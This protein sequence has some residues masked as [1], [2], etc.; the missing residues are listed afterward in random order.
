MAADD[1]EPPHPPAAASSHVIEAAISLFLPRL[2]FDVD[3][4]RRLDK[5]DSRIILR[6]VPVSMD[7]HNLEMSRLTKALS[8]DSSEYVLIFTGDD[9]VSASKSIIGVHL[10][11]ALSENNLN[12]AHTMRK[13]AHVFFQLQ[14]VFRLLRDTRSCI[15]LADLVNTADK[16]MSLAKDSTVQGTEISS[17]PY[18]IGHCSGQGTRLE[19]DPEKRTAM[20]TSGDA[21][22]RANLKIGKTRSFS[23]VNEFMASNARMSVFSPGDTTSTQNKE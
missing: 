19:I 20:L 18:W 17:V 9:S 22:F 10:A 16:H 1:A 6:E 15:Q 8:S 4:G 3:F 13:S 5:Q 11:T 12:P 14:P 23:E 7:S 21:K 2:Q